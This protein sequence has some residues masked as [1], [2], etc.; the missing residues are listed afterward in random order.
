[1]RP[2]T[3]HTGP[4]PPD[5]ARCLASAAPVGQIAASRH[6]ATARSRPPAAMSASAQA[7]SPRTTTE[8][9]AVSEN[10]AAIL[11]P[12]GSGPGEAGGHGPSRACGARTGRGWLNRLSANRRRGEGF[13]RGRRCRPPLGSRPL[14]RPW[15]QIGAQIVARNLSSGL[16]RQHPDRWHAPPRIDRRGLDTQPLRERSCAARSLNGLSN[17]RIDSHDS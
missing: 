11:A 7:T 16:D 3:L 4:K 15:I 13:W 9:T 8:K 17:D 6:H 2:R 1:M 10:G 12:M 14:H 5:T